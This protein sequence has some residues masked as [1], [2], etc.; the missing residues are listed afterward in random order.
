[1]EV[2]VDLAFRVGLDVLDGGVELG[3]EL[4]DVGLLG[5]ERGGVDARVDV[6]DDILVKTR[7]HAGNRGDDLELRG[8]LVDG[9]DARVAH[10]A[11]D[12]VVLHVAGAAE[13]R[14]RA[15]G[16]AHGHLGGVVLGHRGEHLVEGRV[17]LQ[18]LADVHRLGRA[19]EGLELLGEAVLE[20]D[21]LRTVVGEE[22][23]G[24]EVDGHVAHEL[25]E[26]REG[27]DRDAELL[28][29]RGVV[30]GGAVAGLADAGGLRGDADAGAVHEGHDVRDEAALALAD[31][32]RRGVVEDHLAGRGTVDAELVLKAADLDRRAL[33]DEKAG[34]SGAVRRAGLGAGEDEE[35]VAAAVRDEALDAVH[36]PV[37]VLVL[38]RHRLDAL[39]VGAG[40]RF[41]E[42]HRARVGAVA[43]L[44]D[45]LGLD[46]LARERVDRLGDALQAEDVH[47]RGV[48][49][50]DDVVAGSEDRARHVESAQ[51]VRNRAA[52]EA[53]AA[54]QLDGELD[55][56]RVRDGTVLVEDVSDAVGLLRRRGNAVA[57]DVTAHGQR[58]LVVVDGVRDVRRREVVFLRELE[59]LLEQRGDL[60]EVQRVD[61]LLDVGVVQIEVAH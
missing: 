37:A 32:L 10:V 3:D 53:R 23:R 40:I 20:V 47:Q 38:I 54:E 49:A 14:D 4:G 1:M 25:A 5:L 48:G 9:G 46:V 17:E 19:L 60:G 26:R 61:R 50:G 2:V 56:G 29:G 51:I 41:R 28:A 11:L 15:V 42:D 58:A 55:A 59:V 34:K 31:Q 18:A 57:D 45:V 24:L 30:A 39:E 7:H 16:D 52:G 36:E 35:D 8:A 6:G 21:G 22:T 12:R 13:D 44:G 33:L 27:V 43:E